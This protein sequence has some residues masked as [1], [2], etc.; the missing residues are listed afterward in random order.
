MFSHTRLAV[1]ALVAICITGYSHG[2]SLTADST[3]NFGAS[4]PDVRRLPRLGEV[5]WASSGGEVLARSHRNNAAGILL[6]E[7]PLQDVAASYEF[8]CA[9]PCRVGI[10]LRAE[11][12]P[13]G[14]VQGYLASFGEGPAE[15]AFVV[16]DARAQEVSRTR[17]ASITGQARFVTPPNGVPAGD[18]PTVPGVVDFR[19]FKG[20]RLKA[21][22]IPVGGDVRSAVPADASTQ[23]LAIAPPAGTARQTES[24]AAQ[25]NVWRRA[26]VLLDTNTGRVRVDGARGAVGGVTLDE[27]LSAGPVGIFVAPGSGDVRFR[28]IA[29]RDLGDQRIEDER[30]SAGFRRQ[31][32]D[33]FSYAWDAAVADIDRDGHADIVAGPFYYLGPTFERRREIYVAATY[34]P[35]TQYAAN[36][37][38]HAYDF[39]GDGWPDVLATE[40][41]QMVLYVN[42][43]GQPRRWAR[44]LVIPGNASELT[45]LADLDKDGV[46]EVLIVQGGRVAFAKVDPVNPT[47]PWPVFLVSEPGQSTLH[48]FGAGDINGDGRMDIVQV[49]GWWAQPSGGVTAAAWEFHPYVFRNPL[50]PAET[51]E[52]GGEMAIVDVNDDGLA[53]VI[54]TINA[55]GWGLAWYEQTRIAGDISF[56]GH[57]VMGD[58]DQS[59]AGDLSVSQLHAGVIAADVNH[60]GVVDFFT[61]KKQWAHLDSNLDPDPAGSPYLLLYRGVR[62]KALAGGVRFTPEVI[63]NR[64]GVG[65]SF[66]VIDL[67]GDGALDVVTSAVRGTFV[68]WGDA[69]VR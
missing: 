3:S 25:T 28:H 16:F 65:S 33:D 50:L 69:Q 8:S 39:T 30:V 43:Q 22:I 63:H 6:L 64:S 20:E 46:P 52:G 34:S 67:N 60:D 7:R 53:D 68:F 38:T 57:L 11:R 49:K 62:D 66:T 42:P 54:S 44:H 5:V 18:S 27:G 45:L 51:P 15:F 21:P 47:A 12:K 55:H 48:S 31:K 61:G 59:N 29:Y 26:D 32:L 24:V 36:M 40:G 14:G 13:D 56:V 17:L 23:P 2:Q 9:A 19:T 35:G 1:A 4:D 37:I 58:P 10:L 41:R